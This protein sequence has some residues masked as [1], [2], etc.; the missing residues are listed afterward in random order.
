MMLDKDPEEV[1]P[2]DF[3]WYVFPFPG[4]IIIIIIHQPP[5]E[6]IFALDC[7]PQAIAVGG[8][9]RTATFFDTRTWTIRHS[10]K[11]CTKYQITA[12]HFS[13]TEEDKCYVADDAVVCISPCSQTDPNSCYVMCGTRKRI[14]RAKPITLA[15]ASDS[16]LGLWASLLVFSPILRM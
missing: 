3:M 7:K 4:Y 5:N 10:W 13:A 6:N 8:A 16:I 14:Q 15:V 12:L 9:T 2:I 11:A 1:W